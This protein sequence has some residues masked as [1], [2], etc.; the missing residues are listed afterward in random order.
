MV[1]ISVIIPTYNSINTIE[2]CLLSLQNNFLDKEVIVVDSYSTDGTLEVCEK[3]GVKII[4]TH[5]RGI[6][7][8]RNIGIKNANGDYILFIDSDAAAEIH[9]VQKL[10]NGFNIDE[11]IV[12]V[13]GAVLNSNNSIVGKASHLLEFRGFD[14]KKIRIVRGVPTVNA[15]YK[16]EIFSEVG[17][18][19]EN[20]GTGEDVD[21]NWRIIKKGFKILYAPDAI[22]W[23]YGPET[24]SQ[25]CK[26]QFYLGVHFP[27][28][29]EK[30]KDLPMQFPQNIVIFMFLF[31]IFYLYS[32]IKSINSNYARILWKEIC[33]IIP[34][35]LIGR[36][37]FF[38]GIMNTLLH[39]KHYTMD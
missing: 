25:L 34:F 36:L 30:H 20:L 21:I 11:K 3:F 23:H 39:K 28:V 38:L 8:A 6:A 22:V 33:F 29:R 12:C 1:M 5:E 24:L 18:F 19:D 26:K 37:M 15:C 35:M 10:L 2:E 7:K 13:G 17:L 16:K 4:K 32:I 27:L 9:W 31:P 14:S